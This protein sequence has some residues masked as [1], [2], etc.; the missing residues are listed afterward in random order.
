MGSKQSAFSDEQL[1]AYQDCTFF[2]KKEILRI[3]KRFQEL[4]PSAIPKQTRGGAGAPSQCLR[5]SQADVES[6]PEFKVA[7]R[8]ILDMPEL[9]ENPF[10][11]RICEV[12]SEDGR[13]NMSFEDF[14]DMFSVFSEAAPRDIKA[15]YAFK[16]YDFDGDTHLGKEDI[17]LTLMC[18]TRNEMNPTEVEFICE[19]I[20]EEA[21][22]DEDGKL[23]FTEFEHVISRAPDFL[24]TFHI[25]I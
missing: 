1:D 21:D 25:R 17:V 19:K 9:K 7:A 22:L 5:V 3:Y 4:S 20:L 10:R 13:G 2:S 14:L 15:V 23:S 16:I 11:R 24:S 6:M 18:L 12:F 8:L